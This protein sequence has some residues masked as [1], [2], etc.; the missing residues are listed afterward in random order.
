M[1]ARWLALGALALGTLTI[2]LDTTVLTVAVPTMAVDLQASTSQLQW[3]ANAYT[4]V[5][6]GIVLPAGMLGDRYGRKRLLVG[7]LVLFGLASLACAFAGDAGTL[8]A[9]RTA[10][11]VGAA[12]MM[13]LSMAVLPV[14]FEKRELSRAMTVW[15]TSVALGLP[16]GPVLGGWLLDNFWWGSVFL[17]N[18][19][20]IGLAVLAV[21]F[22][23]PESRSDEPVRIDVAGTLL[24]SIALLGLT[25]GVIRVGDHDFTDAAALIC[26]GVAV[27]TGVAFVLSQRRPRALVDLELF[28]SRSFAWGASLATLVNFSMFGLMFTV[29]QFF[30]SVGG[31]DALGAGLRLLP[32]IGGLIVGARIGEKLVERSGARVVIAFGYL[33]I[34][35]GLAMGATTSVHTGYGYTAIWTTVMGAG[36]GFAMPAA[37]SAAIGALPASRSGSGSSLITAL[38][39]A[40]GTIGIAV[41]GTILNSGYRDHLDT[42]GLPPAVADVAR[43]SV[44]SAVA[45]AERTPGLLDSARAAFVHG[46]DVMLLVCAAISLLGVIAPALFMSGRAA[47]ESEAVETGE[48]KDGAAV[49]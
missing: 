1:N 8:I 22:F 18:V 40:G 15:V 37:M 25:Y 10:L 27:V 31:T 5:L 7:A 23:V 49:G 43:D 39:Q 16:L 34:A 32:M 33:L 48:S 47:V 35:G 12:F 2:G 14:M 30:Q 36:L 19:P 28:R 44:N 9:A 11:G 26:L 24:S 20:L 46:M 42:T 4:L 41:L 29:P 45:V 3:I 17:I 38:R 13:P 6:A 21:V